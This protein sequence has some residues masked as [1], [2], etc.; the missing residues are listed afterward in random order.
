MR[1]SFAARSGV[2]YVEKDG[3]YIQTYP[4]RPPALSR[5]DAYMAAWRATHKSPPQYGAV[6]SGWLAR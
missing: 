5:L 6:H 4:S 1:D 3:K 2:E